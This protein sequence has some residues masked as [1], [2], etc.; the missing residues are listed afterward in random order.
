MQLLWIIAV[1]NAL[2]IIFFGIP[3]HR[4]GQ[5]LLL[6]CSFAAAIL[7]IIGSLITEQSLENGI[8]AEQWSDS[9]LNTPRKLTSQPVWSILIWSLLICALAFTVTLSLH[10]SGGAWMFIWPAMTL[11][12]LKSA[13]RS[14]PISNNLL[15]PIERPKPLQ[16]ENW[17]IPS[18]PF[19]S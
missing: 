4:G 1:L 16:S 15:Q 7:A 12:R 5:H 2:V 11:T 6:W 17:G 18:R 19:S 9:L 10:K 8:S 14:K 3:W 13:L